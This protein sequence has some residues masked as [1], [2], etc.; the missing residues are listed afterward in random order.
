MAAQQP[1]RAASPALLAQTGPGQAPARVEPAADRPQVISDDDAEKTRERLRQIFRQYPPSLA[2]VL[3]L[4]PSLLNNE[5][6]LAPYPELLSFLRQ[7]PNIAHNP[8]FFVGVTRAEWT[9]TP[10]S[11][12]REFARALDDIMAGLFILTGLVCLMTLMGWGVR[13]L[14]DHR[15]WLRMS[16]LQAEAHAKVFDRLSSNED[17]LAYIQ[18]P[19]GQKYLESAPI[20]T[21][22]LRSLD[23]PIG[24]ILFTAQVGTVI[25]FIG[26]ALAFIHSHLTSNANPEIVEAAPFF[27]AASVLGIAIGVGFLASAGV[28]YVLSRRLGLLEQPGSSHA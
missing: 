4:D 16:K 25:T 10:P 5:A 20:T 27:F 12:G 6:Y 1:G 13:K 14:V 18:S 7:H 24:R 17:L 19:A 11:P 28:A 22:S 3:R 21:E 23:A 8:G 2:D 9:Q 15:R 26:I